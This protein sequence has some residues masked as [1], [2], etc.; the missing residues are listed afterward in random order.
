VLGV[1]VI[2]TTGNRQIVTAL[3]AVQLRPGHSP[4]DLHMYASLRHTPEHMT[5]AF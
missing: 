2:V 5:A 4:V 1:P 3:P